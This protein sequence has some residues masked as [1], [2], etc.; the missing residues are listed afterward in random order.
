M[1]EIKDKAACSIDLWKKSRFEHVQVLKELPHCPVWKKSK[2]NKW[3]KIKYNMLW[4]TQTHISLIKSSIK[5][6][7]TS[8]LTCLLYAR[9]NGQVISQIIGELYLRYQTCLLYIRYNSKF[10]FISQ[11]IG[12]L[13]LLYV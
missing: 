10:I 11:P 3:M 13:H 4:T 12:G 8:Y 2:M 5:I 7:L 6:C 1:N 9:Y